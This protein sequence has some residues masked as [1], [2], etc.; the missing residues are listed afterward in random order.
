MDSVRK[1]LRSGDLEKDV[2][3]RLNCADCEA[4]L[5]TTNDPDEIGSVRRCP[6]CEEEWKE[7]Q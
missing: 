1:A 7:L 3:G 6:E 5:A 4:E 2:Y